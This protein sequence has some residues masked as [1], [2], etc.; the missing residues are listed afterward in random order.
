MIVLLRCPAWKGFAIFG[1]LNSMIA[2]FPA[3]EIF[4]PYKPFVATSDFSA[5]K[6]FSDAEEL[7]LVGLFVEDSSGLEDADVG[8][9]RR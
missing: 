4:V 9:E 1:L 6:A 2:R 8:R 3:P 5:V 7:E